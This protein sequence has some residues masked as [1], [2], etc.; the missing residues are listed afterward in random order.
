MENEKKRPSDFLGEYLT[1]HAAQIAAVQLV[2][3]NPDGDVWTKSVA[4]YECSEERVKAFVDI[5]VNGWCK[6]DI[7]RYLNMVTV[8]FQD[9]RCMKCSYEA[10]FTDGFGVTHFEWMWR[11]AR[12]VGRQIESNGERCYTVFSA[13]T[14]AVFTRKNDAVILALTLGKCLV[15]DNCGRIIYQSFE[16]D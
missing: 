13:G 8:L 4:P 6:E 3:E 2:F 12:N 9:G 5:Y 10:E 16:E 7:R 11:N 14:S 1:N 15:L